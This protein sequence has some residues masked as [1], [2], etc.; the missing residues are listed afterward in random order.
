MNYKIVERRAR[1]VGIESDEEG[2][3]HLGNAT[4]LSM[5]IRER[6]VVWGLAAL[7]VAGLV[8]AAIGWV[9]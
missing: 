7:I 9:G 5:S 8:F 6:L 3:S 1:V 2:A 4:H